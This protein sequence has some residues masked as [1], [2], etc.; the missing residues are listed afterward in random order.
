KAL[1]LG[2]GKERIALVALD[3]GRAPTRHSMAVIRQRVK[4]A[5]GIEHLFIVGSHTHHGPVI[6]LD[7]WPDPKNSYVRQLERKLQEL[8]I[9]AATSVRPAR[10]G[11]APKGV[12][13]NRNRHSKRADKP[14]DRE[15]LVVRVEDDEGKPIAHLVNFAAHPTMTDGKILKFS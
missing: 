1:F 5:V 3:L 2:G 11:I 15:L 14:V 7:N 12:P 13:F 8:I 4:T 10:L 9:Q 6:E